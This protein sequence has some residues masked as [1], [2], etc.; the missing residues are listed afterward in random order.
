M[1]ATRIESRIIRREVS[2]DRKNLNERLRMSVCVIIV[3]YVRAY[4][5]CLN[6]CQLIKKSIFVTLSVQKCAWKRIKAIITITLRHHRVIGVNNHCQNDMNVVINASNIF[7]TDNMTYVFSQ[8][9][10]D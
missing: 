2:G 1:K 8:N 10:S 7:S 9:V 4:Q 6:K 5:D 3:M